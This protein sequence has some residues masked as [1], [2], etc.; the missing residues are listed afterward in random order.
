[1]WTLATSY[2]VSKKSKAATIRKE[3]SGGHSQERGTMEGRENSGGTTIK[4]RT[5]PPERRIS[6]NPTQSGLRLTSA[7]GYIFQIPAR[8]D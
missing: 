4:R 8:R 7:V 6:E 1:M 2:L 5:C 3:I